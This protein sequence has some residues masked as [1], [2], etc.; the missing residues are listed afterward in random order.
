M[1]VAAQLCGTL[2][3]GA[4]RSHSAV[5]R[6]AVGSQEVLPAKATLQR[7]EA[8]YVRPLLVEIGLFGCQQVG[9]ERRFEPG[10]Q[11]GRQRSVGRHG[12]RLWLGA[13]FGSLPIMGERA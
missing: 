9:T 8:E 4:E 3:I 13:R 2:P 12:Q 11:I 10:L 6:H 7:V 1:E 5:E